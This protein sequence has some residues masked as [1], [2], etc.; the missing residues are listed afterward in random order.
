M[1]DCIVCMLRSC[2]ERYGI[3]AEDDIQVQLEQSL[4]QTSAEHFYCHGM[5]EAPKV[6]SDHEHFQCD[7]GYHD[8]EVKCMKEFNDTFNANVSDPSLCRYLHI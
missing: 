3:I 4:N 2:L 7:P 5:L 1:Q 8:E 6:S